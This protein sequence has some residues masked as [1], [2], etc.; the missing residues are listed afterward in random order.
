MQKTT[1]QNLLHAHQTRLHVA[2]NCASAIS[3][4]SYAF[5]AFNKLFSIVLSI[6]TQLFF[7]Y[8]TRRDGEKTLLITKARSAEQSVIWR[9]KLF[10]VV[11][12]VHAMSF[13]FFA[14]VVVVAFS[15]CCLCC[16]IECA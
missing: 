4:P 6:L 13:A 15:V 1:L 7:L 14:T 9:Y 11:D 12:T 8:F 2:E 3:F 16:P 10:D 5:C